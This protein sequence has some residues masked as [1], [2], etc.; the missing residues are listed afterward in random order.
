[1]PDNS[2]DNQVDRVFFEV[3]KQLITLEN[4]LEALKFTW[5]SSTREDCSQSWVVAWSRLHAPKVAGLVSIP[6]RYLPTSWQAADASFQE[7]P[8]TRNVALNVWGVQVLPGLIRHR[9]EEDRFPGS[10]EDTEVREDDEPWILYGLRMPVFLR[11]EKLSPKCYR[12]IN[13][14]RFSFDINEIRVDKV[15]EFFGQID[16]GW[17]ERQRI[18]II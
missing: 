3:T 14:A 1:V 15:P 16:S 12:L 18:S 4:S 2:E 5:C 7:L 17:L 9:L 11:P 6:D 13:A 10:S 8:N